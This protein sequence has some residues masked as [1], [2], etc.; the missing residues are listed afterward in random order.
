MTDKK[1]VE[2]T[3]SIEAMTDKAVLVETEFGV[4]QWIPRSLIKD[5]AFEIVVKEN[6]AIELDVEDWFATKN[7]LI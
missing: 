4:K 5:G 3:C 2:V 1:Y 7:D 6:N